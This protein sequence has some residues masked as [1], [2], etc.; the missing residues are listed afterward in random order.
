MSDI[1]VIYDPKKGEISLSSRKEC[2]VI[3]HF[4]TD[5]QGLGVRHLNQDEQKRLLKLLA[6]NLD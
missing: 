1:A 4:L 6:N 5:T 2:V 3:R